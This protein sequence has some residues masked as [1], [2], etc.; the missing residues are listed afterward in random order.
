MFIIHFPISCT[1]MKCRG[2]ACPRP[3]PL[4]PPV[5]YY[6]AKAEPLLLCKRRSPGCHAIRCDDDRCMPFQLHASV[7]DVTLA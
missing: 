5:H 3:V 1:Y 6:L 2:G 4:P 7:L